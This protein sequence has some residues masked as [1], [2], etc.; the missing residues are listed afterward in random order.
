MTAYRL[1]RVAADRDRRR[2]LDDRVDTDGRF[3]TEPGPC[4]GTRHSTHPGTLGSIVIVG[5]RTATDSG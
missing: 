1:L 3:V 5:C 4:A 2:H